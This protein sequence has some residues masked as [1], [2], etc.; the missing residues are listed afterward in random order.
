[1]KA[2][3]A[4]VIPAMAA[5]V[6]LAVA[7]GVRAQTDGLR[8]ITDFASV[9]YYEAPNQQQIRWRLFGAEAQPLAGGFLVIKQLRMETFA[10][11]GKPGMVVTA[12]ECVYDT[13]NGV[14]S[15]PGHVHVQSGDGNFRVEGDGF[16]W[17][18]TNSCLIISNSVRTVIEGMPL[19]PNAGQT[20]RKQG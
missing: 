11:D 13:L 1:M 6:S 20:A 16:L 12:P 2:R 19:L 14:A 8:H 3:P 5:A 4:S 10:T 7:V 9:E 17:Q 18:Q 15:S